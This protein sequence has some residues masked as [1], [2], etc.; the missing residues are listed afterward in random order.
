MFGGRL[1]SIR[2]R[3]YALVLPPGQRASGVSRGNR[4][5]PACAV[6]VPLCGFSPSFGCLGEVRTVDSSAR[7]PAICPDARLRASLI[8]RGTRR[9]PCQRSLVIDF[10]RPARRCPKFR[11]CRDS[12]SSVGPV[13]L[14][15][16][17]SGVRVLP[18]EARTVTGKIIYRHTSMFD[19]D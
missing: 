12:A 15:E 4:V 13:S 16:F 2:A 1:L 10:S 19:M 17:L 7:L 9:Q 11:L 6:I 8:R 5:R 3:N 18:M 14:S